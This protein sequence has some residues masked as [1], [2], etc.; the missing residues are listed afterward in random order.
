MYTLCTVYECM[1]TEAMLFFENVANWRV[2]M[3][4]G[5]VKVFVTRDGDTEHM[6]AVISRESYVAT[7][8]EI[9]AE[10]EVDI[11]KTAALLVKI[12]HEEIADG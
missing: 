2:L 5:L 1:G 11:E 8:P 9:Q 7:Y 4:D 3:D 12:F 10:F 6:G